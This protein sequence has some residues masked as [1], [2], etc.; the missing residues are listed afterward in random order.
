M[1]RLGAFYD[2]FIL[3]PHPPWIVLALFALLLALTAL[4]FDQFRLDARQNPWCWKTIV[5]W[6]STGR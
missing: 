4:R 2:R 5:R 6:S 1:N 3:P